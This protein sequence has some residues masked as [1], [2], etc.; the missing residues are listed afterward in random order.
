[1]SEEKTKTVNGSCRYCGQIKMITLTEDE[2]LEKIRQTNQDAN[3]IADTLV[4]EQ[5]SCREGQD[6][7]R[8]HYA[9]DQCRQKIEDKFRED[10]PDIADMLL[11]AVPMIYYQEIKRIS[12]STQEHGTASM[13]R[14]GGNMKI[15]FSQKHETEMIVS[16]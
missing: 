8:D 10:Y 4:T 1:M 15:K 13:I 5:C 6:W 2:W 16:C 3:D 14:S 12:I 7:R 9:M 11:E